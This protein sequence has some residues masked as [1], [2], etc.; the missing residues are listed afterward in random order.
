MTSGV[1]THPATPRPAPWRALVWE[2]FKKSPTNLLALAVIAGLV[3]AAIYAP[4]ISSS[5]P[6]IW[7]AEG[8]C[9]SPWL[10]SLFFNRNVFDSGIDL[11][12][13][14]LIFLVPIWLIGHSVLRKRPD[15]LS[16]DR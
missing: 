14:L 7:C 5:Q 11:F 8:G 15:T 1:A 12:F 16:R 13:N 4:L 3:G 6:L 10:R 9:S 2:Q